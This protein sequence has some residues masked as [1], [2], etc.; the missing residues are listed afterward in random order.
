MKTKLQNYKTLEQGKEIERLKWQ[1]SNADFIIVPHASA[2]R[3]FLLQLLFHHI[4][5]LIIYIWI[6]QMGIKFFRN[7]H[8]IQR[9]SKHFEMFRNLFVNMSS[10]H[11]WSLFKSLI[12]FKICPVC[13][14]TK[15][16]HGISICVITLSNF[17]VVVWLKYI[18]YRFRDQTND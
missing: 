15:L 16:W 4:R 17:Q 7:I 6:R 8:Y 11:F 9:W 3:L 13:K 2:F 18:S 12:I 1:K 5:L 14:G 10:L